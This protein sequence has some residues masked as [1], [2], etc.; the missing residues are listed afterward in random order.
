M[1]KSFEKMPM[2]WWRYDLLDLI[3]QVMPT[4][5]TSETIFPP[6]TSMLCISFWSQDGQASIFSDEI[7]PPFWWS[8]S[9][10]WMREILFICLM[11]PRI[12]CFS[13]HMTKTFQY[14]IFYWFCNSFLWAVILLISS[15]LILLSLWT[16]SI[17]GKHCISKTKSFFSSLTLRAQVFDA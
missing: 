4:P 10:S 3:A 15:F 6:S 17:D 9:L 13:T 11:Y 1:L 2:I 12:I 7:N 16:P 14:F 8:S 5:C